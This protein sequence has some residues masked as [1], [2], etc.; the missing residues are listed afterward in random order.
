MAWLHQSIK[1][2]FQ[3]VRTLIRTGENNAFTAGVVH[4]RD[5]TPSLNNAKD[6]VSILYFYFLFNVRY[7]RI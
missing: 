3:P 7:I 5:V 2:N 4:N 1:R 6:H